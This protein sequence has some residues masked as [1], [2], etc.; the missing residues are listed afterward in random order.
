MQKLLQGSPRRRALD[1][2]LLRLQHRAQLHSQT[3]RQK[4]GGEGG[5]VKLW[6]RRGW[7]AGGER[8][9]TPPGAPAPYPATP[10]LPGAAATRGWGAARG[11]PA[12][13]GEAAID[14][15][16][17]QRLNHLMIQKSMG[18]GE[19]R[20]EGVASRRAAA[21]PPPSLPRQHLGQRQGEEPESLR[22]RRRLQHLGQRRER[23]VLRGGGGTGGKMGEKMNLCHSVSGTP[24]PSPP[25][26]ERA[27]W[28]RGVLGDVTPRRRHLAA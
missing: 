20:A 7:V 10:P 25:P 11:L 13:G 6:P 3:D 23:R 8:T 1:P 27:H 9:P 12:G 18:K 26:C 2:G 24:A 19:G 4:R 28:P 14:S 22:S 16:A 17:S 15:E 5:R 21:V